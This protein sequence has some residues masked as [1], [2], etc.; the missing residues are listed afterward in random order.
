M[1]A[2]IRQYG[3]LEAR[4]YKCNGILWF[5]SSSH[6][7]HQ[8]NSFYAESNGE[9]KEEDLIGMLFCKKSQGKSSRKIP[10]EFDAGTAQ[11]FGM[12]QW[13]FLVP[14]KGGR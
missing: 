14:L 10:V 9:K 1:M 6:C 3:E 12:S 7:T 13:L 4:C 8:K 11:A 2:V 5:S